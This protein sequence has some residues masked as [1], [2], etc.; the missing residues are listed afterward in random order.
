MTIT[1][2]DI[3]DF[4]LDSAAS[5]VMLET[6]E[7]NHS[8]WSAPI[9]IVTNHADGVTATLENDEVATFEFAPLLIKRGA[10]SDDLDQSL[11]ITLGD[12]GEIV[13]PLIKQIREANSD[14][15]PQVIY[16]SYAFDVVSMQLTKQKPIEII[17]GLAIKQ[18]N[19]DHQATTFEAKTSDKN[20]VK[21]GK[22]YNLN[23]F[24]DLKG[25]L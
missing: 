9:R 23:D 20:A 7:I 21:T 1:V 13:P 17:K 15:K 6:L 10:T 22:T 5:V 3:K 16:R 18:M 19:R 25:L 24:P 4:H 14:E 2:N 12:L 8:L 11:S